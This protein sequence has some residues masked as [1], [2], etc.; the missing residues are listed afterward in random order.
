MDSDLEG[1]WQAASVDLNAAPCPIRCIVPEGAP[2]RDLRPA[3]LFGPGASHVGSALP[4]RNGLRP[5]SG[6]FLGGIH[7]EMAFAAED[8]KLRDVR[9]FASPAPCPGGSPRRRRRK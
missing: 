5:G 9:Y 1:R 2:S 6:Q 7:S 3:R 8:P 4:H